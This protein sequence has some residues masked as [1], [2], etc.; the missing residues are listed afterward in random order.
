MRIPISFFGQRGILSF[1]GR[2]PAVG[3]AVGVISLAVTVFS[4]TTKDSNIEEVQALR[5]EINAYAL[6]IESYYA[7]QNEPVD[8]R[9]ARALFHGISELSMVKG[10]KV[11]SWLDD[12]LTNTESSS[13]W[14]FGENFRV[15]TKQESVSGGAASSYLKNIIIEFLGN[16]QWSDL[17]DRMELNEREDSLGYSVDFSPP[18]THFSADAILFEFNMAGISVKSIEKLSE[19]EGQDFYNLVLVEKV[20]GDTGSGIFSVQQD[21]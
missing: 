11:N 20:T 17:P 15:I 6:G 5:R 18:S 2:I 7:A 19:G 13:E 21:F 8:N 4:L 10:M 1:S 14:V 12:S 3:T 9:K 16:G